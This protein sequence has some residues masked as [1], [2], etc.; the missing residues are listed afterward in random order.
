MYLLT[1]SLISSWKYIF[2][3][4]E[5]YEEDA[6]ESFLK[7]LRREPS[8]PNEAMQNGIDFENEVYKASAGILREPHR[9]WENGIQRVATLIKGSSVQVKC[10]REFELDGETYLCYGIMDALKA[11]HIY[12]VKFS[13][14]SLT[15]VDCPGKYFDVP[16]T[17]AYLFCV[18]EALDFSYLLS[19]GEDVYIEKYTPDMVRPF[20]EIA[21]EF[22]NSIE[23]MGLIEIYREHWKA[24]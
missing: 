24:K 5:G 7:T 12:D 21:K 17:S 9:K 18:P 14:K 1:Q 19:D 22:L 15:S 11:G 2:D 10:Q 4:F 23:K 13:N 8:E 20:P 16:Q 6:Y 3:C